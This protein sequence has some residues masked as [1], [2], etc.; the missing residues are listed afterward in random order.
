M[1]F[2]EGYL[3]V[4]ATARNA[5]RAA[6]LLAAAQPVR[7]R[8]VRG[9]MIHLR[10]WLVVPTAPRLATVDG[11]DGA[12]IAAQND[13]VRITRTNPDVLIVIAAGR[14]AKG[15]PRLATVS[16]LPAYGARDNYDLRVFG[17]ESGDR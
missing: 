16:R 17:T 9:D 5:G 8:I 13:H 10:R 1:P 6:F 12:L 3:A 7:K 11:D 15:G 14:A 4:V 2:A